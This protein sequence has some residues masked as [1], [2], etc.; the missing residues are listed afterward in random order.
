MNTPQQRRR[1][2]PFALRACY[3]LG[4]TLLLS[5]CA[6]FTAL[7]LSDAELRDQ[8]QADQRKLA[9]DVAP[10]PA[11]VSL[12]EAIARAIK[13]NAGQRL[14]AMEEAVATGTFEASKF[15]MLPKLVASAG[16]RYRDRELVT[17]SID[18]VTA[19]PSLANPYISRD[20]EAT[21]VSLGFSCTLLDFG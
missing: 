5:G 20:R 15:D 12:E 18:S 3:L 14:R 9:Q 1:A 11:T 8:V 17:R 4:G 13:Y 7:P 6:N 21:T 10:L 16:Y 19:R 2:N